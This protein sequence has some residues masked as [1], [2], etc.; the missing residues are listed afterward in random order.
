MRCH[1]LAKRR[2]AIAILRVLWK[3]GAP[4]ETTLSL[5]ACSMYSVM[6]FLLGAAGPVPAADLH[7]RVG[8]L[9]DDS[10]PVNAR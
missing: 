9:A 2:T 6:S 10:T 3:A 4:R 1:S 8:W 7:H 5:S